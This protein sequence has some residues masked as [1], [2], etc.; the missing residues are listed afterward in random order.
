MCDELIVSEDGPIW[1]EFEDLVDQ[2]LTHPRLGHAKNLAEGIK[3]TTGDFVALIDSD[4]VIIEGSLK[5]LCMPGKII[6]PGP[7]PKGWFIVSPRQMLNEFPPFENHHYIAGIDDWWRE[8]QV[9]FEVTSSDKIGFGHMGNQSYTQLERWNRVKE[10]QY[11]REH[12]GREIDSHRHIQRMKED[13][14]Y[15][16]EWEV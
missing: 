13:S 9:R 4:V 6:S 2:Y 16:A 15:R 5:D 12:P 7:R 10:D 8:L 1:K 14:I 11:R 3:A